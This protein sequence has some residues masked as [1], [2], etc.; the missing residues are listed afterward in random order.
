MT[1]NIVRSYLQCRNPFYLSFRWLSSA[2]QM[3]E[4]VN[5][6]EKLAEVK[7]ARIEYNEEVHLLRKK[8]YEEYQNKRLKEQEIKRKEQIEKRAKVE[9]RRIKRLRK[10]IEQEKRQEAKRMERTAEFEEHLRVMQGRREERNA[11][12]LKARQLVIDE[13]EAE[14]HLWMTT[15]E[16]ASRVFDDHEKMQE[17]W[18]KPH[19]I[20]ALPEDAMFWRYLSHTADMSKTYPTRKEIL[21]EDILD[22][23]YMDF[24]MDEEFWSS[25]SIEEIHEEQ[26]R[27]KLYA[28][29]RREG[30]RILLEK[31]TSLSNEHFG[32]E[33][34]EKGLP[35]RLPPPDLNILADDDAMI[36]EGAKVLLKDATKFFDISDGKITK[37]KNEFSDEKDGRPFPFFVAND[38]WKLS[39]KEKKRLAREERAA[40]GSEQSSESSITDSFELL[41]EDTGPFENIQDEIKEDKY[42]DDEINWVCNKI[43]E[44]VKIHEY[45]EKRQ[46]QPDQQS[47]S[48]LDEQD[49]YKESID[50][51]NVLQIFESLTQTQKDSLNELNFEE[52]FYDDS[53]SLQEVA[54]LVHS[55]TD[56]RDGQT[57]LSLEDARKIVSLEYAMHEDEE[58]RNKLIDS[59]QQN[60][61]TSQ[62]SINK[63]ITDQESESIEEKDEK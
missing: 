59:S 17:L 2:E 3:K 34:E 44:K 37:I 57:K 4:K 58:L 27:T 18:S 24:N 62:D 35:K 13:L 60:D 29:V 48:S 53:F 33:Q 28:M 40:A 14:S 7:S 10:S 19:H 15:E 31:Q 49:T 43:K 52:L 38:K 54:L 56:G 8:Y 63:K 61:D 50:V 32:K 47:S 55:F 25:K 21:F 12:F 42:T 51:Q 20:G 41:E 11:R 9:A 39:T 16:E 26:Q 6:K 36:K 1:K 22:D 5:V 23:V 30:R 46:Q 45:L